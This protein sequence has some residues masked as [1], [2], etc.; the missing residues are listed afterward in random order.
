MASA[1]STPITATTIIS[2]TSVNALRTMGSAGKR[3]VQLGCVRRGTRKTPSRRAARD[4]VMSAT[5]PS[6]RAVHVV[7]GVL[8]L[9][10]R[11]VHVGTREHRADTG[12]GRGDAGDV[13]EVQVGVVVDVALRTA[14]E[15]AVRVRRGR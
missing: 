14:T 12:G 1:A 5:A 3:V 2:S 4:G 13:P 11:S 15:R 9:A 10:A 7:V 6:L 8:R